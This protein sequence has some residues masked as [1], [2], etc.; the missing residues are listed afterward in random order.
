M[1]PRMLLFFMILWG[2]A[3]QPAPT[4]T[5]T[6]QGSAVQ[7]AWADAPATACL[8]Y[9]RPAH[10]AIFLACG[11]AGAITLGPGGDVLSLP[12][13][14]GVVTLREEAAQRVLGQATVPEVVV[15]LPV[16]A[17]P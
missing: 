7:I 13:G 1:I 17:Q 3:P 5:A 9:Q 16:V 12:Q 8:W 14:G 2:S 15:A 6:W 10:P 4:L 11:A